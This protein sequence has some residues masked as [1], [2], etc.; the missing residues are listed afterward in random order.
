MLHALEQPG[1]VTLQ[2][3]KGIAVTDSSVQSRGLCLI[4]HTRTDDSPAQP[5][6]LVQH[7]W[8]PPAELPA[9]RRCAFISAKAEGGMVD[10]SLRGV[11]GSQPAEALLAGYV[12]QEGQALQ[13]SAVRPGL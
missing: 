6:S 4:A 11:D 8:A 2:H 10:I 5:T 1:L 9:R 7:E 13:T 12:R 3:T